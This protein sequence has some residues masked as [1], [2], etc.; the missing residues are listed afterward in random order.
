MNDPAHMFAAAS[1]SL[2]LLWNAFVQLMP[3]K[4]LLS[5][6]S[7]LRD[8]ALPAVQLAMALARAYAG[9]KVFCSTVMPQ[10]LA[11]SCAFTSAGSPGTTGGQAA[12]NY[13]NKRYQ[14]TLL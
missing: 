10:V 14:Y 12:G 11:A 3:T 5:A 1:N 9:D 7:L 2:L 4:E 6:H 8:T 13:A